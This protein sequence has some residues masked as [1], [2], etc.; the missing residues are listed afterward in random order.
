MWKQ[1]SAQLHLGFSYRQVSFR[2]IHPWVRHPRGPHSSSGCY[3][4]DSAP[5]TLAE[6]STVI[7]LVTA[8]REQM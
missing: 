5:N 8:S 3:R 7:I 6:I 4:K 1:T 2:P